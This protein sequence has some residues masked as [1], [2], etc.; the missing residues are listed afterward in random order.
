MKGRQAHYLKKRICS[1]KIMKC[2]HQ[3]ILMIDSINSSR[4]KTSPITISITRCKATSNSNNSEWRVLLIQ[5]LKTITP[6][7]RTTAA[8]QTKLAMSKAKFLHRCIAQG[9]NS[10]NNQRL[11]I[12]LVTTTTSQVE[13]VL[14]IPEATRTFT[15]RQRSLTIKGSIQC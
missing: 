7:S 5:Q 10:R 11:T 3:V 9:N 4:I 12:E 1:T 14:K 8:I 15:S 6:W 2:Q 13:P